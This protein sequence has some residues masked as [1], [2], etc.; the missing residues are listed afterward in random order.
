M[1]NVI[2]FHWNVRQ[3]PSTASNTA[4]FG[5]AGAFETIM[6]RLRLSVL[7]R[8]ESSKDFSLAFEKRAR[9]MKA[10]KR[11]TKS[12]EVRTPFRGVSCGLV[13]RKFLVS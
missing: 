10:V 1:V 4:E 12:H 5:V 3:R 6:R 9:A 8:Q 13:D 11:A 7:R 2:D